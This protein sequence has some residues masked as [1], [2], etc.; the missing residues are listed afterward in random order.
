MNTDQNTDIRLH[1]SADGS[2]TLYSE[3]YGQH[4][5]SMHGALQE[6][7]HV[8]IR[9]GLQR[10][11]AKKLR[12]L[13]FGFGTG[14]NALLTLG[15]AMDHELSIHYTAVELHP[16]PATVWGQL[17]YC[18]GDLAHLATYFDTMH[19]CAWDNTVALHPY[20]SL[21]KVQADF[22]EFQSSE[23]IDL[24]YFD[25]FGPGTQPEL[26]SQEIFERIYSVMNPDGVLSTYSCKGDVRRAMIAVGF[27]VEKVPGPPGKREMLVAIKR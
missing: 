12:V 21:H 13:E 1:R 5:H 6:S 9:E 10:C 17:D 14:L 2:P 19:S 18:R 25:A 15:Q 22:L 4:Y 8:F 26:W 20:F 7:E 24:V 27:E 16:L 11:T 23:A 3:Q